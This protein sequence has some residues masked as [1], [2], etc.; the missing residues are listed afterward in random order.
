MEKFDIFNTGKL[1]LYLSVEFISI[2]KG[3]LLKQQI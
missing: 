3:L 2:N 1:K